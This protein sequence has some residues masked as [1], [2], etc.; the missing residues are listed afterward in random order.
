MS[1]DLYVFDNSIYR[2]HSISEMMFSSDGGDLNF[3]SESLSSFCDSSS[4]DVLQAFS[5]NSSSTKNNQIPVDE[6]SSSIDQFANTLL[7]S[8]PPSH[9]LENLSLCQTTHL[10]QPL[11]NGYQDFSGLDSTE[12][13]SED[14]LVG[15]D[16]SYNQIQETF[17]PNSYSGVENVAKYMQ[18]SYSS[19]SFEAKPGFLFQ[20]RF[21]A[22]LESPN[23]HNQGLSSPENSFFA[24]QMRRV[25]STGD[26]QNIRTPH[27]AQRSFSSPLATESSLM[28]E[29]NF[30]VGRYSAEERRERILKYRAKRNQRNFNKT[31]KYA[32]RK[33]LADN[34]PRI[35]GRFARNDEAGEIPKAAGSARDEDEDELWLDGLQEEEED[36]VGTMRGSGPFV[37]S[38]GH[39]QQQQQFHYYGCF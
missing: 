13:K 36:P 3:F 21:D 25:C 10:Q 22:L 12:V 27:K 32:C 39:Q 8:S 16:S 29:A 26:L 11:A 4:I 30:K 38:F 34:R 2:Q 20:P 1:S 18:R 19:N 37:S 15:F 35:R 14:S 28:E 31:I 9:L 23:F 17:V 24:G 6:S 7:S 5:N 33:T